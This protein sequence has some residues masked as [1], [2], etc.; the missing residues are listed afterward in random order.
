MSQTNIP[1][2]DPKAVKAF[3]VALFTK[4]AR[5]NTFKNKLTGAAPKDSDAATK[6]KQKVTA[7]GM[8]IVEIR[9]LAK[10]AG[11]TAS[12]D[13]VDI[14]SG[15]PVM[16]D[17]RISGKMM[18]LQFGTETIKLD[19]MRAG[20]DPGGRMT[21]KR[22]LHDLRKL[23]MA[24]LLGYNNTLMDNLC[25][26]HLAGAR[27]TQGGRDWSSIP[28]EDHPDFGDIV[29]NDVLPPT[30]NRRYVVGDGFSA[31]SSGLDATD[32]L[33]LTVLDDLRT[34]IDESEYPLQGIQLAGEPNDEDDPLF[35]VR[36]SPTGYQQLRASSTDKDWST[37]VSNAVSR[38][39]DSQHPLFR[40]G[41]LLWR[42]MLIKQGRR[43]IRWEAGDTVK[44]YDVA[45][46]S[47]INSV[48][49]PVQFDRALVL[50][51]QALAM[52]YGSDDRNGYHLNWHEEETDHG[53]R[54]EVS[55]SMMFGAKKLQFTLD[56]TKTDHGVVALDFY[57]GA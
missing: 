47:T 53:N 12:Y 21:R 35:V 1:V 18:G 10:G 55:T 15:L 32:K 51:A 45:D 8:P 46:G 43:S 24:N 29:V 14:L 6:L 16:G 27:G 30:I 54:M 56:G 40:N 39:R 2:G 52:A 31:D 48:T 57:S 28:L 44:E 42:N 13:I 50:G 9:D 49:A 19:Q 20:V 17:K 26:V 41:D 38:G 25:L 36:I 3:S 4:M 34:Q 23:S 37:L 7:T 22:T 11:D 5:A 33:T